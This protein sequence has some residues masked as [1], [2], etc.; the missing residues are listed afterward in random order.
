MN[1][2]ATKEDLREVNKA[3]N[4][5]FDKIDEMQKENSEKFQALK[6]ENLEFKNEF[7][8]RPSKDCE[9]FFSNN[10]RDNFEQLHKKSHDEMSEKLIKKS[11]SIANMF[12]NIFKL[13]SIIIGSGIGTYFFQ[14]FIK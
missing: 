10:L 5:I 2:V 14:H 7:R 3:L 8:N 6:L 1:D 9:N 4:K 11:S 13:I 12:Y